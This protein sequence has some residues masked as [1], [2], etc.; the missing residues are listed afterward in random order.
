[1]QTI[2]PKYVLGDYICLKRQVYMLFAPITA[3]FKMINSLLP[4][5]DNEWERMNTTYAIFTLQLL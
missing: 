5:C 3:N 2:G 4:I 1:M